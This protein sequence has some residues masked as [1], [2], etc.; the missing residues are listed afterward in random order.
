MRV[1]C[2]GVTKLSYTARPSKPLAPRA[3]DVER[4][5]QQVQARRSRGASLR[6]PCRSGAASPRRPCSRARR[7]RARGSR[8]TSLGRIVR[9]DLNT[10]RHA[11]VALVEQEERVPPALLAVLTQQE[12]HIVGVR[13]RAVVAVRFEMERH[14]DVVI[15]HH[16]HH[17]RHREIGVVPAPP[18]AQ[19]DR[20][21]AGLGHPARVL[22]QHP[23]VVAC[24]TGPA[25]ASTRP[26]RRS[27]ACGRRRSSGTRGRCRTRGSTRR[28]TGAGG[29]GS[30]RRAQALV[31]VV[32]A[33][34]PGG[35]GP[36][37]QC[38]RARGCAR[39][40]DRR[41]AV[42]VPRRVRET[43]PRALGGR[44][45]PASPGRLRS[46]CRAWRGPKGRQPG[47]HQRA[48]G[49]AGEPRAR[50]RVALR[51]MAVLFQRTLVGMPRHRG[52]PP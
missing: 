16:V 46:R 13:A 15:A 6:A 38:G 11:A 45:G 7:R 28:R 1:H 34:G 8:C 19:V 31:T 22:F 37:R 21:D 50:M 51:V 23:E 49:C 10:G 47:R 41:G 25:A 39:C 32:L 14:L 9:N 18:P 5:G 4:V 44:P 40:G 17:P 48:C 2:G 36:W 52:D 26:S 12:H 29:R 30:V 33:C 42:P 43:Q 24:R 27:G 3:S 35:A 20:A